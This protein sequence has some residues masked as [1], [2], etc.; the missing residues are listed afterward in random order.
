MSEEKDNSPLAEVDPL[1][2]NINDVNTDYPLLPATY[3]MLKIKDAS[4]VRNKN[5]SGDVL[6]CP[7]ATTEK[8]QDIK[9]EDVL[10]GHVLTYRAGLEVTEKYSIDMIKKAV[11]R[12]A[13][14]AGVNATVREII[15]NP[16]Q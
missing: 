8:V 3:Y 1:D 5:N 10:P 15:N 6:V 7:M 13:K 2:T 12:V 11:A 14:A 4:V 9:G 16:T